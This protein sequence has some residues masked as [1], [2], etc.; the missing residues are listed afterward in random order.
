MI[1]MFVSMLMTYIDHATFLCTDTS[2]HSLLEY[3]LER[4][5]HLKQHKISKILAG[6]ALKVKYTH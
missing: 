6:L 3:A 5:F 2:S 1:V 4:H